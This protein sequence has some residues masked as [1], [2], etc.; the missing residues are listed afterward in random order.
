MTI[1][2][3]NPPNMKALQPR[4][5]EYPPM[6]VPIF[7][8]S[9]LPVLTQPYPTVAQNVLVQNLEATQNIEDLKEILA[10]I[11]ETRTEITILKEIK[12]LLFKERC[13][14]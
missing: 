2:E 9:P 11:R 8:A 5:E 3:A 12:N 4:Q 13:V 10:L 6:V 14:K 1:M 7:M